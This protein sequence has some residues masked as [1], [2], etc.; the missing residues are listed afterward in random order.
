MEWLCSNG[1]FYPA[2][3]PLLTSS[4]RSFRYGD[5][6]FETIKLLNGKILLSGLH[7]DRL[8]LSLKLLKIE[9]S[10][11]SRD[12][13]S[14][15][16]RMLCEKNHCTSLAR[17]RL[18]V[19]R[20]E[21]G[22]ADYLIETFPLTGDVN[23]WNSKG[24]EI[25]FY[26]YARKSRDAFSNLKSANYL[27][28]V[29]AELH[30]KENNWDEALVLNS[31]NKIADASKANIFLWKGDTLYTPALN[32]GCISG[33]MRRY[34]IES[35]KDKGYQ[36]HQGEITETDL[37]E[38][39]EIFLTNAIKGIRWVQTFYDRTYKSERT[40]KIYD[41]LYSSIYSDF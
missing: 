3:L 40:E 5:G 27:L 30:A 33:V 7:F 11:L 19:Y 23:Q 39:D 4:N 15:Q 14:A 12:L 34:V 10:D 18:A 20:S 32:Q 28:Y 35:L 22:K 1:S 31:D 26:P 29:M 38:A 17:I 36:I 13:I 37:L 16:I 21:N 6:V 41:E 8:F 25:G 9:A 24:W 2:D